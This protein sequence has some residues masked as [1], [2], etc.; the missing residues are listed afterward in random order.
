MRTHNYSNNKFT[1]LKNGDIGVGNKSLETRFNMYAHSSKTEQA[2]KI[3]MTL[4]LLL[5]VAV[6]ELVIAFS[7]IR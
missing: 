7:P 6:T 5:I 4:A 2:F 1:E 3:T